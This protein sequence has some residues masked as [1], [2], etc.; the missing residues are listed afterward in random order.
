LIRQCNKFVFE[1]SKLAKFKDT[2]EAIYAKEYKNSNSDYD[3]QFLW[4]YYFPLKYFNDREHTFY[5]QLL[6]DSYRNEGTILVY[7]V[8]EVRFR[9]QVISIG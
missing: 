3:V 2:Y 7:S 5:Y 4:K 8:A 6:I 9:I 1:Y